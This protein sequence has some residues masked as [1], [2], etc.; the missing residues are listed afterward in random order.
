M[1][2]QIKKAQNK[3][4]EREGAILLIDNK[5]ALTIIDPQKEDATLARDLKFF[6]RIPELLGWLMK[7][8]DMD[9]ILRSSILLK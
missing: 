8:E 2:I 7:P 4:D 3:E 6:Y 9:R 1:K 5:E